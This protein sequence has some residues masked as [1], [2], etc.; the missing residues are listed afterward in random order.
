MWFD[1]RNLCAGGFI[2]L[3]VVSSCTILKRHGSALKGDGF[4][5]GG[6]RTTKIHSKICSITCSVALMQTSLASFIRSYLNPSLTAMSTS[7]S[8]YSLAL[9]WKVSDRNT[10]RKQGLPN[11]D[12]FSTKILDGIVYI[13]C[14]TPALNSCTS[15]SHFCPASYGVMHGEHQCNQLPEVIHRGSLPEQY[16]YPSLLSW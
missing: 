14:R 16:V 6:T 11:P 10:S 9:Q 5:L 15:V 1:S 2:L 8:M 13:H 7:S 3:I 12:D 4:S